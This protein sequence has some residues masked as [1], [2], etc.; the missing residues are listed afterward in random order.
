MR[1]ATSMPSTR[2]IDDVPSGETVALGERQH[3]RCDRTGGMDDGLEVRVVEIEGVR[4]DA[5]D[6]RGAGH[7]DFLGAPEH[8]RLRRGLEHLHRRQRGIRRVVARSADGA[9]EPIVESAMCLVFDAGGKSAG[10]MTNDELGEDPRDG[11][12]RVV[13]GHRGVMRHVLSLSARCCVPWRPCSTWR[14]RRACICRTAR[15]S[16]A[17]APVLRPQGA[18]AAP[19]RRAHR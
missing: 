11:W 3:R 18:R 7:V 16:S 4:S 9:A 5:V 19:D 13:G 6:Q 10:A 12:R 15:A 1:H 14:C 17:W 2:R 8:R